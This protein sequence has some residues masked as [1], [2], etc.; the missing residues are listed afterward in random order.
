[1]EY[2]P[3]FDRDGYLPGTTTPY[4]AYRVQLELL[5]DEYLTLNGI[6]ISA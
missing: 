5:G 4:R 1:M 2:H 3:E 6:Q